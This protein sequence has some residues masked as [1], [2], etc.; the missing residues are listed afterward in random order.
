[1]KEALL[2][3]E[4]PSVELLEVASEDVLTWSDG[5]DGEEETL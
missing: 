4:S 5:F 1:M 3:Y 2:V